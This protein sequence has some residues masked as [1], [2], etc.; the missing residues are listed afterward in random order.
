MAAED[1]IHYTEDMSIAMVN[2]ILNEYVDVL[3]SNGRV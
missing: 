2:L 1:G 3:E